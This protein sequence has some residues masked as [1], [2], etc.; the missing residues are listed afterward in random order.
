MVTAEL[1]ADSALGIRTH[2]PTE[3]LVEVG[4]GQVFF[5]PPNR[6]GLISVSGLDLGIAVEPNEVLERYIEHFAGEHS[7]I[8]RGDT[9]E[10]ELANGRAVMTELS[11]EDDA[12]MNLAVVGAVH[13]EWGYALAVLACEDDAAFMR[14]VFFDYVLH[15]F[16][17]LT[18]Q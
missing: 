15:S 8:E 14:A 9:I 11:Y 7:G 6:A 3:W 2:Y 10:L 12:V 13:G 16:E 17:F 1:Y 5:I 18:D 4:A